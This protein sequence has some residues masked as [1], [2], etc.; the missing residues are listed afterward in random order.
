[1]KHGDAKMRRSDASNGADMRRGGA[2]AWEAPAVAKLTMLKM[3]KKPESSILQAGD[4]VDEPIR[5]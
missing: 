2:S 3:P 5:R 1:M 4:A